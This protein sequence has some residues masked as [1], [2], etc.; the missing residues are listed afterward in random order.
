MDE[1]SVDQPPTEPVVPAEREHLPEPTRVVTTSH[2]APRRAVRASHS[3]QAS[4]SLVYTSTVD[5]AMDHPVLGLI[6]PGKND[7]TPEEGYPT[8]PDILDAIEALVEAGS[9]K[10]G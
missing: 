5:Q 10:K 4:S 6:V 2:D 9:L 3:V 7:W 1:Q 8:H